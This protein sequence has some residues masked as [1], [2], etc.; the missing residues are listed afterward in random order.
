[1]LKGNRRKSKTAVIIPSDIILDG[2]K[3]GVLSKRKTLPKALREEVWRNH[4]GD[5]YRAKCTVT[6]CT[7]QITPFDYEVGHNIPHSQGGELAL[8]NLRPICGRCNK[9]MGDN[10]TI[11][12]WNALVA[13]PQATCGCFGWLRKRDPPS[14]KN[15]ATVSVRSGPSSPQT[16]SA[17]SNT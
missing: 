6:W 4:I 11:D 12:E 2:S 8:Q 1:M 15:I 3:G 17:S 7:N 10:Y 13:V 14:Q 9:S 5:H 16:T